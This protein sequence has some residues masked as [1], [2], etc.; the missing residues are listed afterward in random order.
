MFHNPLL[1]N[2][3]CITRR[4]GRN[5]GSFEHSSGHSVGIREHWTIILKFGLLP[6]F[7]VHKTIDTA[8]AKVNLVMRLAEHHARK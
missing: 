2:T 1:V 3:A 7:Y 5:L 8:K 6:H 4:A